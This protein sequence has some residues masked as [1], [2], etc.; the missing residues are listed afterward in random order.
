MQPKTALFELFHCFIGAS[1][2]IW[3]RFF[4]L[5]GGELVEKRN[6]YYYSYGFLPP[7][8]WWRSFW[9]MNGV[10]LPVYLSVC[11]LYAPFFSFFCACVL[12]IVLCCGYRWKFESHIEEKGRL[13]GHWSIHFAISV[14]KDMVYVL[15]YCWGTV[16]S[17]IS[18]IAVKDS[19]LN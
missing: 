13:A 7:T 16:F 10:I 12:S 17:W 9:Q 2:D 11:T 19:R 5:G 3:E 4:F 6:H 15:S 1:L 14:F 8:F 18:G